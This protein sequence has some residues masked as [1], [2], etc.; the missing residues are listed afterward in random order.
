MFSKVFYIK[1]NKKIT[2][3]KANKS[4]AHTRSIHLFTGFLIVDLNFI[5]NNLKK[6]KKIKKNLRF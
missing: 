4:I 1:C 3:T 5:T 6:E 2:K